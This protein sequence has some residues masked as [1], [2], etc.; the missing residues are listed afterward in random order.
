MSTEVISAVNIYLALFSENV[1]LDFK[2][3]IFKTVLKMNQIN[4]SYI[5]C[6]HITELDG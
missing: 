5:S 2:L 1:T 6:R 3:L 4:E